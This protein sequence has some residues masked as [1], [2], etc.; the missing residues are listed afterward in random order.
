MTLQ[1]YFFFCSSSSSI[2]ITAILPWSI[3][4]QAFTTDKDQ[5]SLPFV[6]ALKCARAHASGKVTLTKLAKIEKEATW[7]ILYSPSW[8]VYI[9]GV[10]LNRVKGLYN[11]VYIHIY[12]IKI[13]GVRVP[14]EWVL[15]AF[16]RFKEIPIVN[17]ALLPCAMTSDS[18][19]QLY[20]WPLSSWQARVRYRCGSFGQDAWV[21]Y[22][23]ISPL[24]FLL[25]S[26]IVEHVF[27]FFCV[28]LSL[29]LYGKS[30]IFILNNWHFL[31]CK[32]SA[33]LY[34]AANN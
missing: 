9:K 15:Y 16:A 4:R 18:R 28:H 21:S 8:W 10:V 5:G 19:I 14:M 17:Y 20:L 6:V 2:F 22:S 32:N 1:R 30:Q 26:I 24:L 12:V 7:D 33:P 3:M 29:I 27:F 34:F 23:Y 31:L 13:G 25:R 11:Y